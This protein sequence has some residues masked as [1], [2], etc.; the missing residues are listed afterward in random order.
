MI[1]DKT[2]VFM[3]RTSAEFVFGLRDY[4]VRRSTADVDL[5]SIPPIAT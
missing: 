5:V 1:A 2:G 4:F 3:V